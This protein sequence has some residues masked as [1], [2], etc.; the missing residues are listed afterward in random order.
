M[1]I[2]FYFQKYSDKEKILNMS[3]SIRLSTYNF[4][5]DTKN[6]HIFFIH[7]LLKPKIFPWF[8]WM[9]RFIKQHEIILCI[10]H[11]IRNANNTNMLRP[12]STRTTL[13]CHLTTKRH[14]PHK[15]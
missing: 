14:P 10:K 3:N 9:A 13:N 4:I 15:I 11:T 5:S 2:V 7:K 1:S 8:T 12:T 6:R